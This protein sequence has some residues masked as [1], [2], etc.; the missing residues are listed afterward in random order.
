MPDYGP[1]KYNCLTG[2]GEKYKVDP[3]WERAPM[4]VPGESF[5]PV[6]K[7]KIGRAGNYI[8]VGNESYPSNENKAVI[9]SI[10]FG[11]V[12]QAEGRMEIV[13]ED[14]GAFSIWLNAVEKCMSRFVAAETK[15]VFQIG[16][17]YTTCAGYSGMQLS[18]EMES[19][20]LKIDSNLSNGLI[21]FVVKMSTANVVAENYRENNTYGQQEGGK[22]M[23]LEDAISQLMLQCP[24]MNVNFG[25][26]DQSGKLQ[27]GREKLEWLDNGKIVLG[28]PESFYQSNRLNRFDT[29]AHWVE[30]YRVKDGEL[31]KGVVLINDP[32]KPN[33]L[34]ILKDPTPS[35]RENNF[36]DNQRHLGTFIVNGG[37]C[38]NVL[39]FNPSFDV[40]SV[41]A[42]MSSGGNTK[43]GLS[44][45][46]ELKETTKT[47][48]EKKQCDNAGVQQTITLT[49][50]IEDTAGKDAP[51]ETNKSQQAHI[52]ANR[53]FDI[54]GTAINAELRIVGSV[55]PTFFS[56]KALGSLL[57]IVVINPFTIRGGKTGEGC[58]DF[59]KRA[60]CHPY[61]S[62]R[63]YML[64]GV[65]HSV[66]EGSFVTTLKVTLAAPPEIDG[67]LGGDP[68]GGVLKVC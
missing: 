12:N 64:Q 25:Y 34:L 7:A 26:Y 23:K 28:G 40:V 41:L 24:T 38:S 66:K 46:N 6:I 4:E 15:I 36:V 31:D 52:R 10:D 39:E 11:F 48:L 55:N 21:R 29:I 5:A 18:P 27:L 47:D 2:C 45:D 50:Q 22:R 8:T 67:P 62:N 16:W 1:K 33:T 3:V 51:S 59:L 32:S 13:D 14:G 17:V 30:P 63:K 65:D 43:G 58:G 37:K 53:L 44:S 19:N 42:Q 68:V 35:L 57:S 60:E 9:K 49:Q 20:I 61:F 56:F 54:Q